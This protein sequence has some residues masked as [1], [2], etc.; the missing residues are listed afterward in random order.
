MGSII[1]SK[2]NIDEIIKAVERYKSGRT[3]Q[4]AEAK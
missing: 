1:M 2:N 3:S 4:N